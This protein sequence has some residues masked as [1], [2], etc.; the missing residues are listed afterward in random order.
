MTL[1]VRSRAFTRFPAARI[2]SRLPIGILSGLRLLTRLARRRAFTRAPLR[3]VFARLLITWLPVGRLLTR[4]LVRVLAGLLVVSVGDLLARFSVSPL[5]SQFR[6]G[7]GEFFR[8]RFGRSFGI[9]LRSLQRIE[10]VAEHRIGGLLD[11][12]RDP[13]NTFGRF[14]FRFGGLRQEAPFHQVAGLVEDLTRLVGTGLPHSFIKLLCEQRFVRFC[15][16]DDVFHPVQ[17]LIELVALRLQLLLNFLAVGAAPQRFL[18]A[19]IVLF[20]EC[21]FDIVL[22][23]GDFLSLLAE[24]LHRLAKLSGRFLTDFIAK[25][26]K[27]PFRASSLVECLR[28]LTLFEGFRRLPRPRPGIVELLLLLGHLLLIFRLLHPLFDFVEVLEQFALF[29]AKLLQLSLQ[30]LAFP[31]S[32]RLAECVFQLAD[33]LVHVALAAGEV[34]KPVEHLQLLAVLLL[35]LS[36]LLLLSLVLFFVA[37]LFVV[38]FQLLHLLLRPTAGA[39]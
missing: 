20:C 32:L 16:A 17:N 29:V 4:L 37:V 7:F 9:V 36:R 27:F 19:F 11:S 18:R 30:L 38:E 25:L 35:L 24:V 21:L 5:L 2:L 34:A 39:G 23:L 31:I 33:F 26:F 8:N 28:E 12:L 14:L 6:I 15:L 10:L 13:L 1:L 3:I 22:P